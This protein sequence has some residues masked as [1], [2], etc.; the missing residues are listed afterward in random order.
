[1][2]KIFKY[3]L[4]TPRLFLHSRGSG[5]L[6]RRV[7]KDNNHIKLSGLDFNTNPVRVRTENHNKKKGVV[8]AW[9]LQDPCG[10]SQLKQLVAAVKM[11][12]FLSSVC[13]RLGT[14]LERRRGQVSMRSV[15]RAFQITRSEAEGG[16]FKLYQVCYDILRLKQSEGSNVSMATM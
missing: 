10:H 11:S 4:S 12:L 3:F 5:T 8:W 13:L 7:P 14:V 16:G 1:M 2:Y 9:V 15:G 6:S